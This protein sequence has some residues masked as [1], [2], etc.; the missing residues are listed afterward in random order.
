MISTEAHPAKGVLAVRRISQREA[1]VAIGCTPAY[2]CS[3]LNGAVRPSASFRA[4]LAGFLREPEDR[5]FLP[6]GR[7]VC[8]RAVSA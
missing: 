5:L 2:L 7:C 1:A 8:G 4:R 6:S 3:V